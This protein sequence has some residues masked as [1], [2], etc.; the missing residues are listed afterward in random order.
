MAERKLVV[1]AINIVIHPH[2]R[3]M[4]ISLIK[5][6]IKLRSPAT[7]RGDTKGLLAFFTPYRK[8][9]EDHPYMGE[10]IK[11][12]DIEL[13]SDW[14]NI[15]TNKTANEDE[16]LSVNLPEN[17]KP[18]SSRFSF[19]FFPSTHKLFLECHYSKNGRPH[20]FSPTSAAQLIDKLADNEVIRK[21]YGKVDVTA[22]PC[23]DAL[24]TALALPW[25]KKVDLVIKRPNPDENEDAEREVLRRLGNQNARELTQSLKAID[26][27]SIVPDE[28]TKI[29]TKVAANNGKVT[30][31]GKDAE[32]K[33][34]I[35]ST[36]D[37]PWQESIYY[38]QNIQ[39]AADVLLNKATEKNNEQN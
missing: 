20:N 6:I 9:E 34:I 38:D 2:N 8:D 7:I 23:K 15:T 29:L 10:I 26:G 37:H 24:S 12:T 1:G 13:D 30:V 27:M 17:L 4:Y 5:D 21:K 35:Y 14:L 22:V 11:F 36:V 31:E 25:I 16:L 19:V 28:Q 32:D 39:N 3:E 33:K 18:N